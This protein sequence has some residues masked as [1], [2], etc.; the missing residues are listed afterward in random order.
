MGASGGSAGGGIRWSTAMVAAAV[1][2]TLCAIVISD[3]VVD[4]SG[5]ETIYV[6]VLRTTSTGSTLHATGTAVVRYG[7]IYVRRLYYRTST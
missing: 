6:P 1:K 5:T 3:T 2:G 7:T 4:T